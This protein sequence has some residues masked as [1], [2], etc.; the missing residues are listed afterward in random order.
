MRAVQE[1]LARQV[2]YLSLAVH[3]IIALPTK[4]ITR[5]GSRRLRDKS[6]TSTPTGK[7]LRISSALNSSG[8][9]LNLSGSGSLTLSSAANTYSGGTTING[10]TLQLAHV[11]GSTIDA[12]G[13]GPITINGGGLNDLLS[14]ALS[15]RGSL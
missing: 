6:I 14:R 5:A 4:S 12:A 3:Y 15:P 1:R 11:T 9:T 10:G 7:Q 2:H 13:S 8:G